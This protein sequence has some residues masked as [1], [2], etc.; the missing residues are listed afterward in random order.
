MTLRTR[1]TERRLSH[2]DGNS[3]SDRGIEAI[4]RRAQEGDDR[5]FTD[6]Y[7][8]YFDR[9]Y[10]HM[11]V[12]LGDPREAEDASRQ[13]FLKV[14]GLI[15]GYER[16]AQPFQRWLFEL[17]RNEILDRLSKRDGM[18]AEDAAEIHRRRWS[19]RTDGL[20]ARLW[21][22][23]SELM[24]LIE[25]LPE[26]QRRA[27]LLRYVLDFE[28]GEIAEVLE[29]SPREVR[30][31]QRDALARVDRR[32]GAFGAHQGATRA[33]RPPEHARAAAV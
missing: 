23:D 10:G 31:L 32:L 14:T 33:K 21:K 8:R 29:V 26:A 20:R 18:G 16:S 4:V 2:L 25:E 5:A 11:A 24:R 28:D 17:A 27:V 3:G 6:I 22:S 13:V 30:R 19:V 7:L 9:V 12:A 15:S 1:G